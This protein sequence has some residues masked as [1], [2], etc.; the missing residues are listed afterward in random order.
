MAMTWRTAVLTGLLSTA[1]DLS[2]SPTVGFWR[3]GHSTAMNCHGPS[4]RAVELSCQG[5]DTVMNFHR[6]SWQYDE[7]LGLELRLGVP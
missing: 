5:H 6:P 3:G 4:W 7:G 1:M 2:Y